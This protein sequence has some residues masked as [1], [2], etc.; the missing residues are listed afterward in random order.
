M[1]VAVNKMD[2]AHT[3][4][5]SARFEEI[6]TDVEKAAK[7]MMYDLKRVT[8]IPI[9]AL[10]GDNLAERA[11]ENMPWW[12]GPTLAQALGEVAIPP[13]LTD[14]PLR[15]AVREVY[16]P[17]VSAGRVEQGTIRVGQVVTMAPRMITTVVES[18]QMRGKPV[19]SAS[20]GDVVGVVLKDVDM[21]ELQHGAV[22]GDNMDPPRVC[23]Q[24]VARIQ[25]VNHPSEVRPNY[26]PQILCGTS[27]VPGAFVRLM[28]KVD[29]KKKEKIEAPESLTNQ[30][31][32]Q[33]LVVPLR[34]I[35]LSSFE[36]TAG[37]GRFAVRDSSMTVAIG[38]VTICTFDEKTKRRVLREHVRKPK[39]KK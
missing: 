32:G 3:R 5:A 39:D 11:A 37:F 17:G 31:T 1:I 34:P 18:L 30:E 20:A 36:E 6:K 27:A 25:A 33:V 7:K 38:K 21:C 26:C 9:S 13:R 16:R 14:K 12:K 10:L 2:S 35:V 4:F 23:A 28:N 19:E 15:I 22:I 24:F 8:V 29:K